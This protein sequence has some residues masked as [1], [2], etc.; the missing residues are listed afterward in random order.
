MK[1]IFYLLAFVLSFSLFSCGDDDESIDS[2]NSDTGVV[3]LGSNYY[4][5]YRKTSYGNDWIYVNLSQM[6]TVAVSEE[7][8]ATN[9]DWDIAFNR[10]NVRTNGGAS[11]SGMGAAMIT[12]YKSMSACTS[13]P[14]GTFVEDEETEILSSLSISSDD[15]S[16]DYTESSYNPLL[17]DAL[18]FAGPP[19]TY[20]PSEYVFIIRGADGTC[21]KFMA[22]GFYDDRG[23]SGFYGFTC[24]KIK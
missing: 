24:E 6:D 2:E 3:S 7:E 10:Y 18:A 5:L 23:N 12:T 8:H 19:P 1:K 9:M 17:A 22:T 4:R 21:Y 13:V 20:T 16:F 14:D 15:A 11:G